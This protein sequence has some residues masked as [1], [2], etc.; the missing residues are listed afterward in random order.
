MI[1]VPLVSF[2]GIVNKKIAQKRQQ[3]Q[4][5]MQKNWDDL[6]AQVKKNLNQRHTPRKYLEEKNNE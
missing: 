2:F 5:E 1:V 3:D 6:L 4:E